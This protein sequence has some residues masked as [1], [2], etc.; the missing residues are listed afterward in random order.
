MSNKASIAYKTIGEV[1]EILDLPTHVIRFWEKKFKQIS[2]YKNNGRRYYTPQDIDTIKNIKF[3]LYSKGFT[4][5]GVIAHLSDKQDHTK[6]LSS[7]SSQI[8]STDTIAT[9]NN[10][11]QTLKHVKSQ[12]QEAIGE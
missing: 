5:A 6:I 11:I 9:I 2:P 1:S 10:I 3:L 12:L 7:N 8:L 4:I